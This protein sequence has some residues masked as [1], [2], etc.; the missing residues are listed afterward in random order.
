MPLQ[1]NL[2]GKEPAKRPMLKWRFTRHL[3]EDA[4]DWPGVYVLWDGDAP[5]AAGGALGGQDTI[6]S[7]LATHL[8]HFESVGI[9]LP[10]HY[11]WEISRE[12][13]KR[14]AELLRDLR[15]A[16]A[17]ALGSAKKVRAARETRPASDEPDSPPG[18]Q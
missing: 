11:S 2:R 16:R 15:L 17:E 3:V 5:I 1:E 7:R 12:P 18:D 9:P 14:A 4:P 10:T 8:D 13:A 6:R